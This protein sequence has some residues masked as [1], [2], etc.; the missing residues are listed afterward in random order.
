MSGTVRVYLN[1]QGTDVPAGATARAAVRVWNVEAGE[2]LDAGRTT[3]TDSRGLPADP[4]A[5]VWTGA[6]F[7]VVPV[8]TGGASKPVLAP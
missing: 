3:L 6:I 7:R 1:G 2:A 5:A 4:E 8:R